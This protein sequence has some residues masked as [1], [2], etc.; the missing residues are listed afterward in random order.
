[1]E[2]LLETY[3][4]IIFFFWKPKI[5]GCEGIACKLKPY[6]YFSFG[7]LGYLIENRIVAYLNI[8]SKYHF[9][10]LNKRA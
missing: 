10:Y 4:L 7:N 3:N 1:V 8:L 6:N 2:A 9:L 5:N